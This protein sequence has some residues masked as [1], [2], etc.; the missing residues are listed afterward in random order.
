MAAA[1]DEGR[2]TVS[3]DI[4]ATVREAIRACEG[5]SSS[6]YYGCDN[7]LLER[8]TGLDQQTVSTALRQLWKSGEVEGILTARGAPPHLASIKLVATNGRLWGDRGTFEYYHR[9]SSR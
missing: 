2:K 6:G 1:G 4:V 8:Q 5:P 3:E 9:P 7:E